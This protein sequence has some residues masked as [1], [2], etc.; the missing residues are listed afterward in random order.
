MQQQM[1]EEQRQ[2]RLAQIKGQWEQKRQ[3]TRSLEKIKTKIGVYSG[4]GGVGKTTVA[5]NL[6]AHLANS[7]SKVGLLDADIDCP[8]ATKV[9]GVVEGPNVENG[10][11]QPALKNGVKVVSMAFFQQKEDEAIIWRGPMI[12]NAINQ[13]LQMTDWGDL[14]YLIVDMPPGT[15]D[16]PLTIMQALTMDGFIVVTTPQALAAMD[17]KRSINMIKKLNTNVLGIVEN[18][19]SD[20]FGSGAGEELSGELDLPFLGSIALRPDYRDQSQ[21]S[22]L[23]NPEIE[24]EFVSIWESA[25]SELESKSSQDS[26]KIN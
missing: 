24:K 4:K 21:A 6:A 16:A 10:R 3:I 9:L 11:I 8:N 26:P 1:S 14:D 25:K 15:S 5:V 20:I 17:A 23:I 22:V 7:G 19:T 13:F 2:A 12:H 18:F